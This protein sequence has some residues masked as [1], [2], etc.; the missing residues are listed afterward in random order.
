MLKISEFSNI[1]RV[2]PRMLRYYEE[3]GLLK[4]AEIDRFTGYRLYSMEQISELRNITELR[5]AGFGVE[6][7]AEALP[8]LND[9]EYMREIINKKR[10]QISE[11]IVEEQNKLKRI[12][13]INNRIINNIRE[14]NNI[15]FIGEVELKK[16]DSVKVL[17]LL[18]NMPDNFPISEEQNLWKRMFDYIKEN[19]IEHGVGGYSEYIDNANYG[20][21]VMIA[22]PV[23]NAEAE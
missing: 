2:S 8:R 17:A 21:Q 7:I 16:L 9:V 10:G 5:D 18:V 4:P 12:D 3:N 11:I 13:E 23:N 19:N 6:E 20:S 22:V 15:M 1:V 14:D